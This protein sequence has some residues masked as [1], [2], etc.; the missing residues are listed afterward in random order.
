MIRREEKNSQKS[1]SKVNI[2]YPQLKEQT[3]WQWYLISFITMVFSGLLDYFTGPEIAFSLVYLI[4]VM[5]SAWF[6][7]KPFAIVVSIVSAATWAI[8]EIT[9]GRFYSHAAIH[10]WNTITMLGF[11]LVVTTLLERLKRNLNDERVLSRIDYLT[12]VMNPRSFYEFMDLEIERSKRYEHPFTIAYIDMDN[13]KK[14]NDTFGH[15]AGDNVLQIF[16][17]ILKNNL[18]KTDVIARLGGDEF[19]IFLPETDNKAAKQAIEKIK[20][21][22][23]KNKDL[24]DYPITSSIGVLT[25]KTNP[26]STD[27]IMKSVDSL[28]Y[29]AK[30]R[31]KN[32]VKY[33]ICKSLQ[34]EVENCSLD[35]NN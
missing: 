14:I 15:P 4:P 3:K 21:S 27:K 2:G 33:S 17:D 9:S 19:V 32:A 22:V 8:A 35:N 23:N 29:S 28:M 11:F 16:A 12:G 24:K 13:F 10:V 1:E 34:N 31:G 25:Y 30:N 18:R 20:K 6:T 7:K 26:P 5:T